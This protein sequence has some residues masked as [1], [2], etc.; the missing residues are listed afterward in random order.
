MVTTFD[1][2]LV[3]NKAHQDALIVA[4]ITSAVGELLK[5]E[6]GSN[7]KLAVVLDPAHARCVRATQAIKAGELKLVPVSTVYFTRPGLPVPASGLF[8]HKCADGRSAFMPSQKPVLKK[9]AATDCA[10]GTAEFVVPFWCV[11]PECDPS[12]ASINMKFVT[13]E[14]TIGVTSW[15]VPLLMSSRAIAIDEVLTV[16][17]PTSGKTNW[18]VPE[19]A[20]ELPPLKKARNA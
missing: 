10:K 2:K 15:D 6:S 13:R 18:Y 17:A 19:D 9:D 1:E 3:H 5:T 16:H 14:V 11:K 20:K 7:G 8:I 12:A 4:S